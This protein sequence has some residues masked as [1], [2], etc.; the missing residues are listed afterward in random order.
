MLENTDEHLHTKTG[1]NDG[2]PAKDSKKNRF[3]AGFD[4]SNEIGFQPDST[5]CH[6]DEEFGELFKRGKEATRHT[7]RGEKSR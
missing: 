6:D 3:T 4:H 7:E 1:Q 2:N 5:H